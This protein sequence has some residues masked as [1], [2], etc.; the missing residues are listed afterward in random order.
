MTEPT[1]PK[2]K[3]KRSLRRTFGGIALVALSGVGAAACATDKPADV[4]SHNLSN[5][6]D[7]FQINRQI[8]VVNTVTGQD[9]LTIRGLCS[10]GNDDTPERI[11]VTCKTGEN[12]RGEA[13][14]IK[15]FVFLPPTVTVLVQ[16]LGSA[17]VSS[18]QYSIT[19]NPGA[20]VPDFNSAGGPQKTP[21]NAPTPSQPGGQSSSDQQIRVVPIPARPAPAPKSDG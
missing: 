1:A 3:K 8:D 20:L 9:L 15:D 5:S 11:S 4:V 19:W 10:L 17:H 13:E 18:A 2:S 16:Q 6:A 21:S 7:N 14:Y 12:A